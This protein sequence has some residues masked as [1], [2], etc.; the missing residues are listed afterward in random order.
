MLGANCE[1]DH[2][3]LKKYTEHLTKEMD[4]IEGKCW[5]TERGY[6]VSFKLKLVPADQ[7]WVASMSG[8]LNNA[9]TYFSSFANVNQDN[10][11]TMGGSIGEHSNAT[12]KPWNY[13]DRM[14][15]VKKVEK[16][17]KKL[18]DPVKKERNKVTAFISKERSRQEY[19]PALGK[20]VD[21][22]KAE[23][24]HNTNNAWQHFFTFMLAI[25][26]QYTDPNVLKAVTAFTELTS[27]VPIVKFM[28]C[29][30]NVVKCGRLFK[31]FTRWF[32]EKRKNKISFSYRFTGLESKKFSWNFAFA[33]Q[34]LLNFDS[35]KQSTKLKLHALAFAALQLR[36]AVAIYSRVEVDRELVQKLFLKCNNYFN[37][38]GLFHGNAVCPT[39]WTVGYAIP[40]HCNQLFESI[41]YGLGLNTMQGREA[42]HIKLAKYV[43]NTCNVRKSD[44]WWVVFRHEFVSIVWMRELDPMSTTYR[45]KRKPG[46]SYVPNRII[47]NPG[48]YCFCGNT[49]EP[50]SNNKCVVCSSDIMSMIQ[51]SVT[52]CKV[53]SS[54][55]EMFD[56][57]M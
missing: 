30:R 17:K 15:T 40:Y 11:G 19:A 53:H 56:E 54:L 21:C 35:I 24:L 23:P 13:D 33:I 49:M 46:K 52:D 51:Q 42:K 47:K 34:E 9:A 8:E 29:I 41:G 55:K 25:A 37:T 36:E 3:L 2:P 38:N 31:S 4:E 7:K 27:S 28:Y 48:R 6:E 22:V 26:M 20:Y 10:K 32:R 44:R 50:E 57:A 45:S 1:E 43:Q 18:K 5:K 14:K 39:T 16:F 12:W